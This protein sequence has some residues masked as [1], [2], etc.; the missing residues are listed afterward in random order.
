[1][2]SMM[3]GD[4]ATGVVEGHG[5]IS[6]CRYHWKPRSRFRTAMGNMIASTIVYA[7]LIALCSYVARTWL[8]WLRTEVKLPEPRWRSGVTVFGFALTTTSLLVIVVLALP[9]FITAWLPY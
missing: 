6:V 8:R 1:M 4:F 9:A 3:L 2:G 7:S 5:R